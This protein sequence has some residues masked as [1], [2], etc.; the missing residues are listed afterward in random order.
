MRVFAAQGRPEKAPDL[1]EEIMVPMMMPVN[2]EDVL[3]ADRMPVTGGVAGQGDGDRDGWYDDRDSK[4]VRVKP[5]T[6]LF[7]SALRAVA[8][9]HE[10]AN[11]F[12]GG[13]PEK[14]RRREA[15]ASFHMRLTRRIVVLA[16][17][18]DLRQDDGFC[19]ALMPC[20]A[21]AGYGS[22]TH[23]VYLASNVRRLDHLRTRGGKEH[24]ERLQGP[25]S[26][27]EERRLS[28]RWPGGGGADEGGRVDLTTC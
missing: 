26:E 13:T 7:S 19:S 23:V 20:G 15:V 6:L 10:V 24:L 14:N 3:G 28:G 12:S 25:I 4:T 9:S 17:Q 11:N 16:E 22:G 1:L 21:A 5:T 2:D 18:A 8:R 27:N